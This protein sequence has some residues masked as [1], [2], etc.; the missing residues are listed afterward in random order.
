MRALL[1]ESRWGL[2]EQAYDLMHVTTVVVE[3]FFVVTVE[4]RLSLDHL[5]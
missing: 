2:P 3:A 1:E 5:P 4:K